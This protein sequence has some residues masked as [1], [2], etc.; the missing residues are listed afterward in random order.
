MGRRKTCGREFRHGGWR[1][2]FARCGLIEAAASCRHVACGWPGT[3][4]W[5]A[6]RHLWRFKNGEGLGNQNETRKQPTG[7]A[8]ASECLATLPDVGV[9]IGV[10]GVPVFGLITCIVGA[11]QNH[12]SEMFAVLMLRTTSVSSRIVRLPALAY[13][14]FA[15]NGSH[16]PM[17]FCHDGLLLLGRSDRT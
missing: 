9:S 10:M 11:C 12:F 5:Q 2:R 7:P 15:R 13:I 17:F 3:W 14:K 4:G 8:Q 16:L 6:L 1:M